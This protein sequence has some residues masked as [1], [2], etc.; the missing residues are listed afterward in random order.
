MKNAVTMINIIKYL[1]A[2]YYFL[3]LSFRFL[4]AYYQK[5]KL[6]IITI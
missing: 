5:Q 2:E 6:L 4:Y 3:Y 1:Q